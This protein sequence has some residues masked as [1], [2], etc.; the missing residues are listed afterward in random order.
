MNE[1]DTISFLN[2]TQYATFK[3]IYFVQDN[4]K[5][6][7]YEIIDKIRIETEKEI[8]LNLLL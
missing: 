4:S 6:T 5:M 2:F 3:F 1:N 7:I 8:N